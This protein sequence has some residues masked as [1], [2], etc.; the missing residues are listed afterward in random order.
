MHP[1]W[2]NSIAQAVLKLPS[3]RIY[4]E[5]ATDMMDEY[6]NPKK[7]V[8]ISAPAGSGK[9]DKLARRYISLLEDNND[10][11][12]I[13]AITFTEKA[14]AEMKDRIL[15]ILQKENADKFYQIKEKI[16]LMRITTIHA[17][18]RKLITRFSMELGLDP[19][20]DVLDEFGAVQLWSAS[21]YDTLRDEKNSPSVFSLYLR[22]KGLKGWGLIYRTLDAIHA[23]RPYS[24]FLHEFLKK[25][26]T[27]DE[28]CILEIYFRCLKKYKDKKR[29]LHVIDFNDMEFLAYTAI[30]S[31]PE[32]LNILY[33][34]DEHTDHI[35]VDEFQDTNSIQW[36]IIDKLTEEWRSGLGAKRARGKIPTIF[37]VGDEKQSIY[38]F[39]GANV[40]VFQKVKD[41]FHEWFGKEAVFLESGENFRSLP[42]IIHFSNTLFGNLMKGSPE[43]PWRT[44]YS[45]FSATRKGAGLIELLLLDYDNYTRQ[46]RDKEALLIAKKI[47]S[48]VGE[49]EIFS[50]FTEAKCR[51][52]D[53]AILMRSRTH[54]SSFESALMKENIPYIVEGGIGFYDEPEVAL[55]RELLSFFVD[56]YDDFSLFEVLRSPLFK[57]KESMLFPLLSGRKV[58]FYENLKKS[59]SARFRKTCELLDSY[60]SKMSVTSMAGVIEEFLTETCSWSIFHETQR[61]ANTKKFLRIIER[62]ESYGLS[63]FEIK[64]TLIRSKKSNEAKANVNTENLDAVK[65]MTVHGAKGRQFPVVFLPSLDESIAAKSSPVFL[66]E[67]GNKIQFSYEVDAV[68][69]RKN[70]LFILHREKA[71]EEEK[72]L[73]YVAVTRAMD[74]LFM[75]GALKKDSNGRAQIK[76]KLSFIEDAFPGSVSGQNA[77]SDIFDVLGEG[78]IASTPKSAGIQ[79]KRK[80]GKFFYGQDFTDKIDL[81]SKSIQWVNVTEDIEIKT[82][83]GEDWVILGILFH[84]LFEEIS[85]GIID[86]KNIDVRTD[87][88]LSNELSLKKRADKYRK[89]ILNSFKKLDNTG[90]LSKIIMP[91]EN[92]F[93][94]LPFVLQKGSKVYKG[95]IDRVILNDNTAFIY[96]YKTFPVSNREIKELIEKYRFQMNIYSEACR[97]LFTFPTKCFIFFTHTPVTVEL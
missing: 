17:F 28:N 16:P 36:R 74:H 20:L 54:L 75:S 93:A 64:E 38:M 92:S 95:R 70:E 14:A 94:E 66:D 67:V 89:T 91:T 63:P 76:G 11:E 86:Y 49:K 9:T 77:F 81:T 4:T 88:L 79:F 24:E 46:T 40:S 73:F 97:G 69:R 78:D 50:D 72:R 7:S 61:H 6:L 37:L 65:I 53:I 29:E 8:V 83:H 39:R 25:D 45:P 96:D 43:K 21:V 55:L 58:S 52:G 30:T 87:K 51:F 1:P 48:I 42:V 31:N 57:F 80:P 3:V 90:F 2:R 13:L 33:A 15:N 60:R 23:R 22:Q 84:R 26:R 47:G 32:W 68:M 19:S 85:K 41:R 10:V 56:P 35:L 18:C 71:I 12:K 82:K 62:Y 59:K 44:K 27:Y 5:K 34:F